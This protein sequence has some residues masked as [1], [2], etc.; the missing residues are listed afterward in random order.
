MTDLQ[1]QQEERADAAKAA[2]EAQVA[3]YNAQI[4]ARWG[5]GVLAQGGESADALEAVGNTVAQNAAV[6]LQN[7][8]AQAANAPV[9][10]A[11]TAKAKAWYN[12]VAEA[13]NAKTTASQEEQNTLTASDAGGNSTSATEQAL[14][15]DG[16]MSPADAASLANW[17]QGEVDNLVPAATIEENLYQRP[18]VEKYYPAI[19]AMAK[20]GVPPIGVSDYITVK[21][22]VADMSNALGVAPPPDSV[23]TQALVNRV[24]ISGGA[25]SIEGRLQAAHTWA[26]NAMNGNPD[27]VSYLKNSYGVTLSGLTA[28]ALTNDENAT[29][30]KL[31]AASIAGN[32]QQQGFS[33]IDKGQ[34]LGLAAGGVS[35]S[36]TGSEQTAGGQLAGGLANAR[37]TGTSLTQAELVAANLGGAAP[38]E[39]GGAATV[40]LRRAQAGAANKFAS[41]GNYGTGSSS[42]T[43]SATE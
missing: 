39:T 16:G 20:A 17:Y 15:A 19:S 34:A 29:T 9:V 37:I 3:A 27:A 21:N 7:Q 22:A 6:R 35:A 23:L 28:Y 36:E 43:G 42:S 13:N 11:N 30:N 26:V 12:D 5:T 38:G 31:T 14:V 18:E 40:A 33:P 4:T 32:L 41:G 2:E 1:T 8:K 25:D 24:P 10:A